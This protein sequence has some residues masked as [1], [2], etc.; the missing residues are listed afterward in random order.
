M[1]RPTAKELTER[2]LEVMQLIAV[3]ATNA[4]IAQELHITVGTAKNHVKN[5]Y[6]KLNVH[7]RA[8]AIARS[9][10]LGLIE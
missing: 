1:A 3:G 7:N 5:I 6:S 10:E 4:E 8:Q 2:E 9:R